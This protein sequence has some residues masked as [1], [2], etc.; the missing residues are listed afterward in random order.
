MRLF[1][2]LE[3]DKA[4][5]RELFEFQT[6]LEKR[7]SGKFVPIEN[8]HITLKFL[9]ETDANLLGVLAKALGEAVRSIRPFT[10]RLDKYGCF[11]R[12]ASRT[13]YVS[14]SG[15]LDELKRLHESLEAALGEAGFARDTRQL[16]PHI[17]LGREVVYDQELDTELLAHEFRSSFRVTRVALFESV[18]V[19]SRMVYNLL[20]KV[21]F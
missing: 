17:T 15:E 18:R 13:A 16:K 11:S 19:R 7:G 10:L 20:H 3:I 14:T 1:I 8:Y 6:L 5:R 9:G 4:A 2:A 12:G 21:E